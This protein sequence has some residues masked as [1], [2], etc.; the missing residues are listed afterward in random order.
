LPIV[1]PSPALGIGA[2]GSGAMTASSSSS[3][4]LVHVDTGA[5]SD[6]VAVSFA[7]GMLN[8]K[9]ADRRAVR[10]T[11]LVGVSSDTVARME[12]MGVVRQE[13]A[14]SGELQLALFTPSLFPSGCYALNNAAHAVRAYPDL[15][16]LKL[17]KLRLKFM[18]H[19]Q[20]WRPGQ[21]PIGFEPGGANVYSPATCPKSY[22][23]ALLDH[24]RIFET[25]VD[26]IAHGCRSG[27]YLCLLKLDGDALI[28][29]LEDGEDQ[30]EE[31]W[32]K[33][34]REGPDPIDDGSSGSDDDPPQPRAVRELPP[35]P[36]ADALIRVRA[37]EAGWGRCWVVKGD[38]RTKVWFDHCS[39]PGG[40]RRAWCNCS[41]HHC[42]KLKPVQRNRDY[43]ASAFALWLEYGLG[44]EAMTRA[45][46]MAWWPDDAAIQAAIPLCTFEPF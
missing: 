10:S 16:F 9:G 12:A 15:P 17:D 41:T 28:K 43:M 33:A 39:G 4:A 11:A 44:N 20:G 45:E 14:A 35:L 13:R 42:G 29:A 8:E 24:Q 6:A 5:G 32:T 22:Y 19:E 21:V 3:T 37:E 27:Y 31:H 36:I 18:M 23:C 30:P 46:H 38:L 26:M 34:L 7:L 1:V 2:Q 25:G 40:V